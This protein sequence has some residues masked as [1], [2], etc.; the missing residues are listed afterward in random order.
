M[1]SFY[2]G[3][4]LHT[5]KIMFFSC[6][7]RFFLLWGQ[8]M[9]LFIPQGTMKC[10][11]WPVDRKI[12]FLFLYSQWVRILMSNKSQICKNRLYWNWSTQTQTIISDR[13]GTL[14]FWTF[15][16]TWIR[17]I[18]VSTWSKSFLSSSPNNSIQSMSKLQ[19]WLQSS[20]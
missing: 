14:F 20:R 9:D 18:S 11:L 7:T 5:R 10:T 15:M 2:S 1:P 19:D 16:A 17:A 8:K 6:C 4:K 13:L 3:I 12:C